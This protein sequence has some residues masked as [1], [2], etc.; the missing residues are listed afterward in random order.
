[1]TLSW[2]RANSA[3]ADEDAY[4]GGFLVGSVVHYDVPE[5]WQG[6]IRGVRVQ[7]GPWEGI[8]GAKAA[9]ERAWAGRST[10]AT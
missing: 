1:M 3:Y 6:F 9:V 4:D 8:D 5:G 7:G 10:R 2:S